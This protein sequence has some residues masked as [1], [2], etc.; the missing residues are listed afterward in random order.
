MLL[1]GSVGI[2]S[3]NYRDSVLYALGVTSTG[4]TLYASLDNG[5]SF[6]P[7]LNFTAIGTRGGTSFVHPVNNCVYFSRTNSRVIG[8]C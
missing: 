6:V 5:V 1:G 2:L 4:N 8:I 7:I 3:A